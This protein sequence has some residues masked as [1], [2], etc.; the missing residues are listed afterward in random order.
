[1]ASTKKTWNMSQAQEN[2]PEVVRRCLL[3]TPQ[4]VRC[5]GGGEVVI[6]ERRAYDALRPTL[7]EALLTGGQGPD[8][9][10]IEE[11]E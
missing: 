9:D 6:I 10:P 5:R 3:G 11:K 2:F 7:K 8:K 1:M 4:V